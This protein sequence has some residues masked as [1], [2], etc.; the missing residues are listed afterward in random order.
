MNSRRLSLTVIALLALGGCADHGVEMSAEDLTVG[1]A[2]VAVHLSTQS[3][4]KI[5]RGHLVLIDPDGSVRM[6]ETGR[7]DQSQID[8]TPEGI[9]FA[10][11]ENDY[12]LSDHLHI[13]ASPKTDYSQ[14][15]KLLPDG[16]TAAIY[17]LGFKDS[18]YT[19]EVVQTTLD[20]ATRTE[21]EGYYQVT[22][23]CN[24]ILFGIAEPLGPYSAKAEAL[25]I[26]PQGEFGFTGLMLN[27]LTQTSSGKEELIQIQTVDDSDQLSSNAPCEDGTL[28]HFAQTYVEGGSKRPTPVLRKWNITTGKMEQLPLINSDD[29]QALE[30]GNYGFEF[31]GLK[32]GAFREGLLEWVAQDGSFEPLTQ[33][34]E[35]RRSSFSLNLPVMIRQRWNAHIPL[36]RIDWLYSPPL[37]LRSHLQ[38]TWS[39]TVSQGINSPNSKY[40][41]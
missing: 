9:A 29:G 37:C 6:F 7:M 16:T 18:G 28:Y 41:R 32:D 20:T 27:Q 36:A 5:A 19:E 10:D 24:D 35:K 23:W 13:V 14:D 25:G 31:H 1:D 12:L 33:K 40:R 4:E 34:L 26:V 30:G 22:G 15:L 38:A 8:W 2:I 3:R 11:T 39:T 21:I 17:N